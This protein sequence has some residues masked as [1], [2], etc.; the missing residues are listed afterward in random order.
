[1]AT[2]LKSFFL[3]MQ[4][5]LSPSSTSLG[6]VVIA[7][8]FLIYISVI[9]LLIVILRKRTYEDGERGREGHSGTA[10]DLKNIEMGKPYN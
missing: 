8:S 3:T 6:A 10:R 9:C 5:D 1:M 7:V 2:N 4:N